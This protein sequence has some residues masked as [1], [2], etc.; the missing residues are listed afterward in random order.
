MDEDYHRSQRQRNCHHARAEKQLA[1]TLDLA[2]R[3]VPMDLNAAT[4]N[5]LIFLEMPCDYKAVSGGNFHGAPAGMAMD[6]LAIALADLASMSERRMFVL[7]EYRPRKP[8][9][10]PAFLIDGRQAPWASIPA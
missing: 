1:D 4:D 3:W 2:R 5:P 6:F 8:E 10:L 7:N 9:G